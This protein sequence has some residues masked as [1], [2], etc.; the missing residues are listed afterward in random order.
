[1]AKVETYYGTGRRKTSVARVY[2]RPGSGKFTVVNSATV[3][4][5]RSDKTRRNL[6][7]YFP[8]ETHRLT[9]MQPLELVNMPKSF[10]IYINVRGGG[11]HGQ[12]G[13]VRHGITRALM[14]YDENLR[15]PLKDAGFVTRDPRA[16]ERKKYGLRGAR[17][18]FQFSK[19]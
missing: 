12:A 2:I 9:V 4:N 13:A 14:E 18:R 6:E 17:R 8:I 7:E 16:K 3:K 15:K 1:M 19:R 11:L 5:R 10:D